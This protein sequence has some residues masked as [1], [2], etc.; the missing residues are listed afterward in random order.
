MDCKGENNTLKERIIL[1]NP[2]SILLFTFLVSLPLG[3][4]PL[5]FSYIFLNKQFS[6]LLPFSQPSPNIF[7]TSL[8]SLLFHS[9][10]SPPTSQS[11]FS[12]GCYAAFPLCP[13]QWDQFIRF[14]DWRLF[15]LYKNSG[16]KVI[17]CW[18]SSRCQIQALWQMVAHWSCSEFLSKENNLHCEHSVGIRNILWHSFFWGGKIVQLYHMEDL[19]NNTF[20]SSSA[21]CKF[22]GCAMLPASF[23]I[24]ALRD[25][26]ISL[27]RF[28]ECSGSLCGDSEVV[29]L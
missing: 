12:N 27:L 1:V 25:P 29:V 17:V 28:F 8:I 10:S 11:H 16:L 26:F 6:V 18:I 15:H 23:W 22:G 9:T 19:D 21:I 24:V 5:A 2:S 20:S 7:L 3:F 14:L 13:S 4:F